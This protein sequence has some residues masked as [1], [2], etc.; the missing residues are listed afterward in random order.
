[1][2]SADRVKVLLP[3]PVGSG[4]DY[5]IPAGMAVAPGDFVRV[6]LGPRSMTGVVWGKADGAVPDG[7]LKAIVA[8]HDAPP[9]SAAHRR[10]VDW[11]A[12][13]TVTA[14]GSV[15]R[16]VM[17]VPEALDPPAPSTG[18][19]LADSV[20][21]APGTGPRITPQR[22][23]VIDALAG[24]E[25]VA[26]GRLRTQADVSAAV[27]AGMAK[28]GLIEAAPVAVGADWP[29]PQPD[30]PGIRLSADQ[31]AAVRALGPAVGGGY[32]A[33]LLDGV[34]GS[35]KTEVYFEAIAEALRQSRQSIVLL[36]EIALTAQW[37][38]RF[39]QRFGTAPAPWHS[40][41]TRAQR[42]RI[43]RAA[44]TGAARVVVGARSAL[45]LPMP[46]L[47][48]IVVD[49]EH[50][51]SFKQEDGVI[52]H[53]RDMAVV[54]ATLERAAVVLASATPALESVANVERG[55]YTRLV[56]PERHGGAPLP[57]A[58]L[59]DLRQ[60]GPPRG[61]WLADRLVHAM[62]ETLAAGEQAL[63]YLNRRGYAPLTLCRGC[64][65]RLECPQCAAW[66][67]EHR[68]AGRLECHHCGHTRPL[69]RQ[70]PECS[71]E[72]S[73]VPCGPGVERLAEEVASLLPDARV[74]VATSD[75]VRGPAAAAALVRD[76]RDGAV[77]LLI[78][79]QILAKGH[80]FP[81]L[82]LVGVV[83]ADLGLAGGDLRAAE[84]T[85]QMLNQV[86][87]R[88]GRAA[89]PGRV[90]LQS[91]RPDHPVLQAIAAGDRDGFIAAEKA[92]RER[93][94]MPP[95][96]RLAA[97]VVSGRQAGAVRQAAAALGRGAPAQDGLQVLGP[98]PA[99]LALLRGHFRHRLLV[100]AARSVNLQDYI[101]RWL[102]RTPQPGGIRI[103]VD[104][105]PYSFS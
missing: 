87:G 75:T 21:P 39:E 62:A 35:G 70:C 99:P 46:A 90:I 14:P 22:R 19:R 44:A 38:A 91:W 74:L 12:A 64:G 10:F 71:A 61:R 57:A 47:G 26:T 29:A 59:L 68:L 60:E 5:R 78:G 20:P 6:P 92:A 2:A 27:L 32:A 102:L 34:T 56:L 9:L 80:H 42:R 77:D 28:A 79:T 41:L 72:D 13:Y 101:R 31:R 93:Y 49:E 82:T 88:A 104:I 43:W 25:P 105:D 50:D 97:I 3:M 65:L 58:E 51:Q 1:M 95:Y 36:P 23:R 4:Y 66:L 24:E 94:G 37:L 103:K 63:L 48:L 11:I 81:K 73:F 45:M 18:Y 67:V 100:K 69:P 17:P 8:R 86:A 54:R 76:V 40:D 85:W 83:D 7:R 84:R 52:Y 55:R 89:R 30:R 33:F 15:L 96:G 98:T 53:A 16:M